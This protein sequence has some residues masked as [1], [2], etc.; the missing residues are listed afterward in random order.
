MEP[1]NLRFVAESCHAKPNDIGADAV[2]ESICTDTR[3]LKRGSLFLALEGDRF[4]A[5]RFVDRAVQDGAGA[6]VVH[7]RRVHERATWPSLLVPDTRQALRDLA[8][9]YRRMFNLPICAVAGSNGKTTTKDFIAS[10]LGQAFPTL[11]SEASFNNEIGVPLTLLKLEKFHEAAVLEVG[12]NHPGELAP[13]LELILPQF[14]VITSIGAEHLEYFH[15]A[16]GVAEE[17][18]TLAAVLPVDGMLWIPG[19]SEWAPSLRRR[20][21]C[22]V[23]TVGFRADNDWVVKIEKI[24]PTGTAFRMTSRGREKELNLFVRLPGRHQALNGAFAAAVA[25]R[26]KQDQA[27]IVAGLAACVPTGLRMESRQLRGIRFLLDCYNANGDSMVA[28]LETIMQLD[29]AG[30]RI[31]VLGGM[32][33]LGD[34][35]EAEHR[36][37]G[38]AVEGNSIDALFTLGDRARVIAESA[39]VAHAKHF[40]GVAELSEFLRAELRENDLVLLKA[41]RSMSL[42][43]VFENLSHASI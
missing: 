43:R 9:A 22:Q 40:D 2:V 33:E 38:E 29:C 35:A 24:D 36:R 13:L 30:R 3:R 31:A 19:D 26:M 23:E 5:H 32:S 12:T 17:E 42:E 8:R 25:T 1:L 11:K 7:D 21:N 15:D 37:V 6:V 10:V 39:N 20:A 16:N 34:C 28:A 27:A 18:G 4:D 41:S 14:G